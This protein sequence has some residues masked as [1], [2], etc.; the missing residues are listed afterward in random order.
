MERGIKVAD[1]IKAAN[2]LTLRWE[3]VPGLSCGP[4]VVT[5]YRK[6]KS[7]AVGE[8]ERWQHEMDVAS[9]GGSE[10]GGRGLSQGKQAA[11]RSWKCWIHWILP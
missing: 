7:K 2:Q 11:F 9:F 1:G 4:D 10:D 8:S 5:G 6:R 3:D